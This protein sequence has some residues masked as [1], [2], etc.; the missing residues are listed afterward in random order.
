MSPSLPLFS[1]AW[2]LP[3]HAPCFHF[4][5]AHSFHHALLDLAKAL[6]E[7]ACPELSVLNLGGNTLGR[8]GAIMLVQV[9]RLIEICL[10][11]TYGGCDQVK[12]NAAVFAKDK[13]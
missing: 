1:L 6:A 4:S 8:E 3:S 2:L 11:H 10:V 12:T 13:D 9:G 7:G 5:H